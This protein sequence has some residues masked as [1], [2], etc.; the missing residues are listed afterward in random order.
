VVVDRGVE[1]G[2]ADIAVFVDCSAL[3]KAGRSGER[4]VGVP[5]LGLELHF[6]REKR[7]VFREAQPRLEEAA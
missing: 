6:G 1:D 4:T 7:I 3:A 5:Q 2:D